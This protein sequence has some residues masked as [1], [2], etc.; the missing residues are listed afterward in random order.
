ELDRYNFEDLVQLVV[1]ESAEGEHGRSIRRRLASRPQRGAHSTPAPAK[2]M[3]A[4]LYQTL[5]DS[6]GVETFREAAYARTRNSELRR[7]SLRMANAN[8]PLDE[9]GLSLR[10]WQERT[11]RLAWSRP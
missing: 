6:D 8:D 9:L 2:V 10:R 7:E 11:R 3:S 4:R 5:P 1:G